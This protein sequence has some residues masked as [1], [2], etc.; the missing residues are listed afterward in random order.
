[1]FT[2]TRVSVFTYLRLTKCFIVERKIGKTIQGLCFTQQLQPGHD[3]PGILL[4]PFFE[5]EKD[6]HMKKKKAIE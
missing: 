1:M 6:M 3:M 4:F 5:G 2:A